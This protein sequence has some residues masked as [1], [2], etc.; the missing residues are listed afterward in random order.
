VKLSPR[1]FADEELGRILVPTLVLLGDQENIY[2]SSEAAA[3]AKQTIP[4]VTTVELADCAH[5]IPID[6][7]QAAADAI[8]SFARRATP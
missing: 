1:R 5:V 4:E 2:S 6:A 8:R 7:P 3:R